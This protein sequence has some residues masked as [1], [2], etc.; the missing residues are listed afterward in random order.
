MSAA[1]TTTLLVPV[2]PPN[3][4]QVRPNVFTRWLGRSILKAGGWRMTGEFPDSPNSC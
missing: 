1:Q 2:L 4:P 3:A